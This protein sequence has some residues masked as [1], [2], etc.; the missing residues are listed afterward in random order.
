[1]DKETE[2]LLN[3][4]VSDDSFESDSDSDFQGESN[5]NVEEELLTKS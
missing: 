3:F 4:E 2:Q 5:F 1:M